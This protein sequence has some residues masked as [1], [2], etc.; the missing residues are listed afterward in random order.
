MEGVGSH[1]LDYLGFVTLDISFPDIRKDLEALL[2]VVPNTTYHQRV[3]LL[4]GTNVQQK[5]LDLNT[6]VNAVS[7]TKE[8][9]VAWRLACCGVSDLEKLKAK[10]QSGQLKTTKDVTVA[11]NQRMMINGISKVKLCMRLTVLLEESMDGCFPGSLRLSPCV[12]HI[13]PG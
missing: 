4:I 7:N 13:Q 3:P 6:S 9:P 10:P 11:P 5:L 8:L 2:L 1:R 12:T